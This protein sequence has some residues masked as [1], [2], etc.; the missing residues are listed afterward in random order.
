[1]IA[2]V[3]LAM[4][5]GSVTV[6]MPPQLTLEPVSAE[7][8]AEGTAVAWV[9]GALPPV[10][11]VVRRFPGAFRLLVPK[12]VALSSLDV[13]VTLEEDGRGGSGFLKGSDRTQRLPVRVTL[14]PLRL[15][16]ERGDVEV[17]E[18]DVVLYLDVS[19][20]L[21]GEFRGK[22]RVTVAGR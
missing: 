5:A 4:A 2:G 22:L 12:G 1:M 20:A 17:W 14:L 16:G 6:E 13:A 11:V 9:G 10:P 3:L 21:A 15:Q 7:E 8:L 18:G 19:G